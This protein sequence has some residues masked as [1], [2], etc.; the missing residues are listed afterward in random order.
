MYCE[1]K[2]GREPYYILT[3]I[4][5]QVRNLLTVRGLQESGQTQVDIAKKTKLHPFVIKKAM[6]NLDKFS[7]DELIKTYN[8]LLSFD[9][10]SK[11]G[12]CNI[13]DSLYGLIA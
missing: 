12:R 9:I 11:M 6:S 5:Y 4:I 1:L 3:M 7:S 13:E 2:I 8:R 10:N